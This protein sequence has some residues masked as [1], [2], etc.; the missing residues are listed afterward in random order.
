MSGSALR[1]G[2]VVRLGGA[3]VA[4]VALAVGLS[5][6]LV[7]AVP[8]PTGKHSHFTVHYRF[9]KPRLPPSGRT[10]TGFLARA[11]EILSGDTAPA[12]IRGV[13]VLVDRDLVPGWLDNPGYG[14]CTKRDVRG[15][16]GLDEM[17]QACG[18][19]R[20]G[21]GFLARLTFADGHT[22]LFGAELFAARFQGEHGLLLHLARLGFVKPKDGPTV[23]IWGP[24]YRVHR[25]PFAWGY[26]LHVP[27]LARRDGPLHRAVVTRLR[28]DFDPFLQ[29]HGAWRGRCDDGRLAFEGRIVIRGQPPDTTR[30]SRR[31]ATP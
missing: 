7:Q 5:T 6:A 23:N 1:G 27:K 17:E 24:L 25:R 11:R 21:G 12:G 28:M 14:V 20:L 22:E 8:V 4:L 18:G 16:Y 9:G 10:P 31:C 3:V 29:R 15:A 26:R 13:R 19:Q 2:A 30:R